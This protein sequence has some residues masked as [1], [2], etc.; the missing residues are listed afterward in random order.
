MPP[1]TKKQKAEVV[2][3]TPDVSQV[4]EIVE[5]I[6][7]PKTRRTKQPKKEETN[8][9]HVI[10]QL[11][12]NH[13][14]IDS[15][16]DQQT[17][18]NIY[19]NVQDPLPYTPNDHFNNLQDSVSDIGTTMN[20]KNT[21]NSVKDMHPS[22]STRQACFWC[23]HDTGAF[24]YGMPISYDPLHNSFNQYGMFCSLECVCAYN[25][26]TNMGS[27]RMW[28]I[29]GWI[30][31]MAKKLGIE[32]PIRSAP[33]RYLLQLFGG[34]MRIEDFRMCH[35]SLYRAY[36]MN[37]PPMI[38]VSAQSEI[39]NVSFIYGKHNDNQDDDSKTK[40]A[41]KKSIMDT[42]K[43]LDSKMNLTYETV[44]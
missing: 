12:I 21:E 33:S 29:H 5:E 22:L 25:F 42:K 2:T 38:N 34:P 3:E 11:P 35:K 32:T 13:D 43:T 26:S 14:K 17:G 15:I 8:I 1:R 16:L 23:C 39:M 6:V 20:S 7:K 36:V 19:T 41:R 40:L 37:I 18:D 9:E 24:K 10:V 30:Q 31:L 27:D 28:E 4:P 44:N